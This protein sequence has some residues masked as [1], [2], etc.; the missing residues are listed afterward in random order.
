MQ[1]WHTCRSESQYLPQAWKLE[2]SP[3]KADQVFACLSEQLLAFP[4]H[5]DTLH[6]GPNPTNR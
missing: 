4:H 3:E 5:Q 2:D 6:T 1:Q